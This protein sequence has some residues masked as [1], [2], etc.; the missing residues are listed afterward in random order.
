MDNVDLRPMS[1]GEVLDRT[2]T[3][4]REHFLL[5]AGIT[6][7]PYLLTLLFNFGSCCWAATCWVPD[8]ICIP[9]A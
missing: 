4:Y 6:A 9:P 5:F 7:L 1:L 3:T 2:F 8:Q